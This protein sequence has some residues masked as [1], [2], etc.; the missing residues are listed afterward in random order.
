MVCND[1]L[2]QQVI[3][4]MKNIDLPPTR[5]DVVHETMT[6]SQKVARECG[7]KY[8]VVTYDLAIARPALQIQ[9][10]ETPMF[11]NIFVCFGTFHTYMAY[12][13]CLGYILESSGGPV[14]LMSW[15]PVRCEGS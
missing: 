2:P 5:L 3:G 15:L 12:F 6:R 8:T 1:P 14:V 9:A 7:E 11:D 4:Y 13:A 10:Q